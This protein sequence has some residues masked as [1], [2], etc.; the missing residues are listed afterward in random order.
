MFATPLTFLM[1]Y[2]NNRM[3]YSVPVR[4]DQRTHLV[5]KSTMSMGGGVQG[6]ATVSLSVQTH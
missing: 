1:T 2:V 6:E 3:F 4:D 5:Q